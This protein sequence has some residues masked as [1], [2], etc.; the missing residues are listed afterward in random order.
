MDFH[1]ANCQLCAWEFRHVTSRWDWFRIY[2][3]HSRRDEECAGGQADLFWVP[4]NALFYLKAIK[5]CNVQ[6]GCRKSSPLLWS[7]PLK[8]IGFELLLKVVGNDKEDEIPSWRIIRKI[9]V[10]SFKWIDVLWN[11]WSSYRK[12]RKVYIFFKNIINVNHLKFQMRLVASVWNP[13]VE[14]FAV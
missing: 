7:I 13:S 2:G 9:K 3:P 11:I 14:M 6:S 12:F 10:F 5:R 8:L 4:W 1:L